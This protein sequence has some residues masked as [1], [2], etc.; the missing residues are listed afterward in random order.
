MNLIGSFSPFFPGLPVVPLFRRRKVGDFCFIFSQE[1][2]QAAA[3]IEAGG[4]RAPVVEQCQVEPS[5]VEQR[6]VAFCFDLV[7]W[8]RGGEGRGRGG[9][10]LTVIKHLLR[11]MYSLITVIYT[12]IIVLSRTNRQ[13]VL[14]TAPFE[15]SRNLQNLPATKGRPMVRFDL[16]GNP[17]GSLSMISPWKYQ[18]QQKQQLWVRICV[19]RGVCSSWSGFEG[20]H[21]ERTLFM[22]GFVTL[23]GQHEAPPLCG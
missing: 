21:E 15:W 7:G 13:F 6:P 14:V 8:G 17:T 3:F 10:I 20:N 16:P 11:A 19:F 2:A 5:P 18:L 4:S 23:R 9:A 1:P 22:A 12:L